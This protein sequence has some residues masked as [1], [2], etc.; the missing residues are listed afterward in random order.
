MRNWTKVAL[1]ASFLWIVAVVVIVLWQVEHASPQAHGP[2]VH[3]LTHTYT[4]PAAELAGPAGAAS[5]EV[6]SVLEVHTRHVLAL[7]LLPLAAL[8]GALIW[9]ARRHRTDSQ[10]ITP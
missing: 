10:S 3:Y 1:I 9:R 7:L 6:I 4:D 2:L 5:A 8:W